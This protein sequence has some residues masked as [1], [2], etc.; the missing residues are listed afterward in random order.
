LV[1]QVRDVAGN[2]LRD[3]LALLVVRIVPEGAGDA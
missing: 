2:R 1:R 3:D